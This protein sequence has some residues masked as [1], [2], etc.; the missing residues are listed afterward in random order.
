[1][2]AVGVVPADV[3]QDGIASLIACVEFEVAE[4]LDLEGCGEAFGRCVVPA[5]ALATHAADDDSGLQRPAVVA[6]GIL[7]AAVGVAVELE[8]DTG[9]FGAGGRDREEEQVV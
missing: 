3:A 2:A 5:V 4:L 6:A 9:G 7:A 8:G 1:M